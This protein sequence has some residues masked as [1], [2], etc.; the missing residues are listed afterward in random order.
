MQ[1]AVIDLNQAC[2]TW[3]NGMALSALSVGHP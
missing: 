3:L 2:W 1:Q